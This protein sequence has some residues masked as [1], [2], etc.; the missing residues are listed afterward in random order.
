MGDYRAISVLIDM[1]GDKEFS[2]RSSYIWYP[3]K[4]NLA[5]EKVVF[6]SLKISIFQVPKIGSIYRAGISSLKI[7]VYDTYVPVSSARIKSSRL[8]ALAASTSI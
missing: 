6:Q 1:L 5:P 3:S 8:G 7:N 4:I 2:E